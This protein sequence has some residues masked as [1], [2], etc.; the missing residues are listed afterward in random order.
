M[1]LQTPVEYAPLEERL[2]YKNKYFFI[3]SC[4]AAEIGS[5]MKD[6]GFDVLLNPFGVLYNPATINSSINRIA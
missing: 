6:L 2:G 4:F 1:K 3:G 5:M